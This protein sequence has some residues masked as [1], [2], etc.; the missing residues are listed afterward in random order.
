M[1][2]LPNIPEVQDQLILILKLISRQQS[3][4]KASADRQHHGSKKSK[5][6]LGIDGAEQEEGESPW[7]SSLH[8]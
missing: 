7:L 3:P 6:G 2:R 8:Y 4:E 5:R 1:L